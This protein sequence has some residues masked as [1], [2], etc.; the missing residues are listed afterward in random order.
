MGLRTWR[1][2]LILPEQKGTALKIRFDG[3]VAVVFSRKYKWMDTTRN[4]FLSLAESTA[5]DISSKTSFL[6]TLIQNEYRIIIWHVYGLLFNTTRAAIIL[7][8]GVRGFAISALIRRFI[9]NSPT[10]SSFNLLFF[11]ANTGQSLANVYQSSDSSNAPSCSNSV[12]YSFAVLTQT[13]RAFH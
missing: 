6:T 12:P 1:K 13:Q 4:S 2:K 8:R 3:Q 11:A 7:Q 9:V 10:C 5:P